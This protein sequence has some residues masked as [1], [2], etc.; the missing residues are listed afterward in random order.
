MR[1]DAVA[2]MKT[3]DAIDNMWGGQKCTGE[4]LDSRFTDGSIFSSNQGI[5]CM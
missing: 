3:Q 4:T 5:L 2:S 1:R